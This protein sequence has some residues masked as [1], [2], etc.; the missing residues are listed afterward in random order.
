M[1]RKRRSSPSVGLSFDHVS[2]SKRGPTLAL[3]VPSGTSVAIMGT[4][5]SGKSHLLSCILG[6]S[7][8]EQGSIAR[9]DEV[10][11][12]DSPEWTRRDTPSSIVRAK[13]GKS[14]TQ[15]GNDALTALNLSDFRQKP[16]YLLTPGQQSAAALLPAF[17]SKAELICI[18]RLL[19]ELDPAVLEAVWFQLQQMR[20][21]GSVMVFTTYRPDLGE[22]ADFVL[23]MKNGQVAFSGTPDSLRR[24]QAEYDLQVRTENRPG[25]RAL[26]EPFEI[27]IQDTP[28]GL[29]ISAK[30]GQAIAAKLLQDGYGDVQFVILRQP[31]FAEAIARVI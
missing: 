27:E 25:V 14:A 13:V 10:L 17:L 26:V 6:E 8:P 2:L 24:T 7:S 3:D 31:T 28:E 4:A 16:C 1:L 20:A 30:E 23:V 11:S 18:D 15:I 22:R 19:D 9:P 12:I 29:R 5:A 21:K